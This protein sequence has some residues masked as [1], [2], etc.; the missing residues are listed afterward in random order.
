MKKQRRKIP[1]FDPTTVLYYN[2]YCSH[3]NWRGIS[4]IVIIH[5]K[6]PQ[7]CTW[8]HR[9]GTIKIKE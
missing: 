1:K 3:C 2:A 6:P 4:T 5:N 7:Q 8:C 9:K